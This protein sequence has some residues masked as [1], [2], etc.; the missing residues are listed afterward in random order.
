MAGDQND[1]SITIGGFSE[2]LFSSEVEWYSLTAPENE[3]SVSNWRL[4]FSKFT[5]DTDDLM[6]APSADDDNEAGEPEIYAAATPDAE[7]PVYGHF[8]TG[9]PFLG[10]D[11]NVFA[12]ITKDL[13]FKVPNVDCDFNESYNRWGICVWPK[14]CDDNVF[15]SANWTFAF[16]SNATFN[17]PINTLMID[18]IADGQDYCAL[19]VQEVNMPFDIT[20]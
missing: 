12:T 2:R 16:G 15:G 17:L 3:D 4:D 5:F 6:E 14:A 20:T 13:S 10:V 18:Y 11:S 9:Y 7:F 8:N 1:A 19:G